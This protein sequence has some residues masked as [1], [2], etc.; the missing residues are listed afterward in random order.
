MEYLIDSSI[1]IDHLRSATPEP[2]RRAAHDAVN[3]A[4]AVTCEPIWFELLR[5]CP[6]TERKGVAARLMTLPMLHTPAELWR[7]GTIFGQR[8]KDAGIQ[9]GFADL[10]LGTICLHHTVVMVTFDHHFSS[11]SKIIGFEVEVLGRPA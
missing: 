9:A 6:K 2:I 11:L 7:K 1:W 5:L 8:C 4:G 3:R 10:L